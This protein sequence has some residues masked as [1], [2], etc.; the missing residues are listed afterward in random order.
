VAG[1][2]A[3][4][5]GEVAM[6]SASALVGGDLMRG[7]ARL[8]VGG[9]EPN[10]WPVDVS[11]GAPRNDASAFAVVVAVVD[12]DVDVAAAAI[13]CGSCEVRLAGFAVGAV[14]V[15]VLL[16][17]AA[18]KPANPENLGVVTG[19]EVGVPFDAATVLPA[20][21]RFGKLRNFLPASELS[22]AFLNAVDMS[23]VSSSDC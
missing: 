13:S 19:S 7:K 18:P 10:F 5:R 16:V 1:D 20:S 12:T 11:G 9:V 4:V 2:S 21:A 8:V 6:D 17:V 3:L 15:K 14:K 23:S 22:S